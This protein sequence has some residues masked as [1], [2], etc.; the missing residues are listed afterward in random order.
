[1]LNRPGFI[2]KRY[3]QPDKYKLIASD[4]VALFCVGD[5]EYHVQ[6]ESFWLDRSKAKTVRVLQQFKDYRKPLSDDIASIK[7]AMERL[8]GIIASVC[9]NAEVQKN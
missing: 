9:G 6:L 4:W 3:R 5:H 7:Q 1:M 8:E 2:P